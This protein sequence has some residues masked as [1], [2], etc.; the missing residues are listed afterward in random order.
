MDQYQGCPPISKVLIEYLE[1][2]FP[3]TYPTAEVKTGDE[4]LG[5]MA[6]KYGELKVIR[7]LR[8]EYEDQQ[9]RELD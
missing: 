5:H 4:A 3:N 1:K 6:E 2:Q 8:A 9:N 7:Y